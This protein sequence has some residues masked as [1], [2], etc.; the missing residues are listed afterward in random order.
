MKV[1]VSR[2][3]H[4]HLCPRPE[5]AYLTFAKKGTLDALLGAARQA[6]FPASPSNFAA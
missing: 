3:L 5:S 6:S 4:T 1:P 2:L